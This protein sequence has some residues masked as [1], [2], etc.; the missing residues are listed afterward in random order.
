MEVKA[1]LST[2]L[3]VVQVPLVSTRAEPVE[4]TAAQ[5]VLEV[6]ETPSS[7]WVSSLV[8]ALQ[9]VPL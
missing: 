3:V 2:P 7:V 4:S 1:W 9:A 5:K 6:H 8:G